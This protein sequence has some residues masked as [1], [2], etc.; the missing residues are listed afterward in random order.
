VVFVEASNWGYEPD[1]CTDPPFIHAVSTERPS[2]VSEMKAVE[3]RCVLDE[4]ITPLL[5]VSSVS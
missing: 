5:E 1:L 2:E 4:L 3:G